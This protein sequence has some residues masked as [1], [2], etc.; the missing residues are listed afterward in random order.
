MYRE[1]L[2]T[3]SGHC[4]QQ[5]YVKQ[6]P[7]YIF[8]GILRTTGHP[9][10]RKPYGGGD[11][12]RESGFR[13]FSSGTNINEQSCVG[14]QELMKINKNNLNFVNNKLI[15]I[16]A[17][18]KVL[19]LAYEII[20]S[21]PGNMTPGI[22]ST[23][24]DKIDLNWILTV[25]KLLIAGKYEFKP[26]RRVYIPKPKK[27][28]VRPLTISSPRDKVVQQAI[29]LVLNAIYEPSFLDASHGS[30]PSR[31]THTALKD[32][33]FKFQG[34]K[35]CIEA[36]IE[37][38]FPNID[39]KILLTLLRKR[40]RCSKFLALIKKSIK[41][42]YVE[43]KKLVSSNKGLFQGNVTSPILNNI[44][45]HQLDLF[46]LDLVKSFNK[47][48]NR[49]KSPAY[50]RVLYLMEKAKAKGDLTKLQELRKNLWKLNSKDPFDPNFK[51][52]I[53]IRYVDDFVVGVVGS[54]EDTTMIRNKIDEFLK[55]ELKL[56]LSSKKTTITHFS[57]EFI[58]FLNTFIKGTW[59]K[60]K[61][62]MTIKKKGSVSKKVRMTSSVV[63]KAPIK[64][65]FEKAVLNGFF[66]VRQG[67]FIPTKVGRCI[68]LD[69]Q[70]ILRYYN[71]IIRGVLN[72]YS[73]AH[74]RK[75]LGSFVHGLK[76]SC[77]RTLALKYKLRH[78]SKIYKKFGSKLRS[79][80]GDVELFIPSTFKAIKKFSCNVPIPDDVILSNWNKKLTKSNLFKSCIICGSTDQIEMHHVRQV[81]DL[82]K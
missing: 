14:L 38:N 26:A 31:G 21:K 50:R 15:H 35:W 53:Y 27:N 32:I 44:Y 5:I 41:V 79:P 73:F 49:R 34:V 63:L 12:V 55:N 57:K 82:K 75:S 39:H 1:S 7:K 59:E 68:N 10:G 51:R 56:F 72:Y 62:I 33:K 71:S 11:S 17:D 16:V 61:K 66:K 67:Q 3:N 77:A 52:L 24:L 70:D 47:G 58:L 80:D 22:D 76:L 54:F 46:M 40:I 8:G 28:D 78:A 13:R 19:I 45:L 65:I 43:N 6:R 81:K 42:G 20:K 30:R 29:Y 4:Y 69:H 36:D 74:N 23:T 2:I 48:K 25:S 37:S 9:T 60:D 64:S 18:S